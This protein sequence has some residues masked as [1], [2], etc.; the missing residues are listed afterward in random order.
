MLKLNSII[1]IMTQISPNMFW[2]MNKIPIF[3][4]GYFTMH[5]LGPEGAGEIF[6]WCEEN[7][8]NRTKIYNWGHNQWEGHMER[9]IFREQ[10]RAGNLR[11]FI[12]NKDDATAFK[13]RW[14]Q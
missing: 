2:T 12:K 9:I 13:L 10:L 3:W 11:V 7:L 4:I 6:D 1:G 8:S 14:M 5:S